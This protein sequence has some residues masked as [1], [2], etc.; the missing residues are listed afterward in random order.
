MISNQPTD[1]EM[2]DRNMVKPVV[3]FYPPYIDLECS[4]P[5]FKSNLSL[6]PPKPITMDEFIKK[7]EDVCKK[8]YKKDFIVF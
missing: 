6:M 2:K 4:T 3:K 7:V 5:I 1:K 8:T